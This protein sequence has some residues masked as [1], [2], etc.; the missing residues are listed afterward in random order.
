MS[1]TLI[2]D[3]GLGNLQSVKRAFEECGAAAFI[4]DDPRDVKTASH[5]VLP[6]VGSFRDGM[7]QLNQSGWTQAI[8]REVLQ[9][10]IPLLGIC[11][12]MQLLGEVG[13][14]GGETRGLGL[15]PGQV[16][17]LEPESPETRIPHVG[18]NE[19]YPVEDAPLFADVADGT[20]FYFVHSY[21]FITKNRECIM[22]TTPYCGNFISAVMQQNVFGVQ[23]HP[24]KSQKSGFRVIRNFLAIH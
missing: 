22:S 17:K 24:E 12:G 3:Y 21:H 23:F 19:V 6:G 8:L 15:I 9:E 2:I 7:E 18:W 4:S 13:Y 11:L 14:E 20:D 5:L 16:K 10:Q 1:A